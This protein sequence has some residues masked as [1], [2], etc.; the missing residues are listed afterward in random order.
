[1]KRYRFY[2]LALLMAGTLGGYAQEEAAADTVT[3][4]RPASPIKKNVKTRPVS[5]RVFAVTSGTPLGG[6][7]VSVS[8]Y[9]GYSTLTE[10]DGTYKLD[11]PE[12]A[13][14][15]TVTAPD[16]NSVRVGINQSGKLRDV[17]L[18]SSVMRSAYSADDNILNTVVAD[19][20]D[21]SPSLNIT[22]EIGDQLG[23]NVRTISR[24]GTPGIGNFM[25]MNGINSLHSNAQPLIVID[26]VIVD[27]Q[28]DRT[29]VH[30]GFY[31]DI[32]TSFNVNEIKSVKVMA[33]GTAI[34]GAK[35]AN[36]VILIE[37]K[38]NTS[39]ATK[40][41]ATVSAGITLLPKSLPMMSGSQ[42]KTYASDLLKTTGTNLSEFQFLT[43]DPNN[44][45]YNKY[46]NNTDWNDVIYREAFSQ[47]YGITVQGGD[48]VA[49]YFLALGYNG[50]Q[51]VLEDND[52]NRLNI[53]FNTDINMFKHLF[54]RFDASYSNVTR[55]LKDQGAPEAYDEGTVT[56]VNYLGLVKS[57]MLSPYAYSN[58]KI[59][60]V[61]F[62]NSDEDYLDQA[63]S[64]IGN[65]NY[66]LANPA[67]INEYGTAQN[68]N[69]FENSYLNLAVTPK[70]QFNKHL[71][72]S[73]LFSYTLTNTNDKYYVPI[74]GVPDYYV[75]SIGLTVENEIRSLYSSQNSITSDTK[76]EWGNQYGAHSIDLLGGFRYMNDRYKVDTQLGYNTGS[77]KTPFINDTQ[78]K[79]TTGSTNEW[80]SMSW[81]GQARYDYRKRYFVEG[82]LAI[83]SSSRFGK[84]AKEGF[85][86]AGVRWGVFPGIQA[87]WVL[88]NESWFDVPG[89][90]YAKF[91]MGYD[92]SGN[93]GIDF[94]ATRTYFQSILFQNQANGLVLGNLGNTEVQWETTRRFSFG[95]ELNFLKNRLNLKVNVFKSWTDNLLTYHELNFI[96]GLENNW[97]NGGSLENKG[98]N[99]TVN[100]HIIAT[101]N[102]NWELG[103]SVGHYK[104][105][106]TALPD[107]QDYVDVEVY[108]ATIRS[109]I[110]QPV[111]LFYG[112]K[113]E[114]TAAGTSVYATSEEAASDGLYILGE[115]GIDKTYFGAGDVKFADNGDKEI[116]K[117]DM[118]IIGDPN[119]DI[120][121]NIFTSLS[122]KR[123]RLD[124]NFN[125]SLGNDAY[126]YLRSQLE[127][128][129]RFMNQS[130]TMVNRWSYEG[131]KTDMPTATWEDPMG[132]ARFSDRWIEDAS[133]LRLK[134]ITL[135]YELPINNTFIHGLTFWGQAN[136]VFT[137]SKYLGADPDFS[138]SNSVLEQGIDRGLLANSRSFMLGIKINL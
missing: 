84:D 58:G 138:M 105:K 15:L 20:F 81:Y 75:S 128:G 79:T 10:E 13:T 68:K 24:G 65:V 22:S 78:N 94:D 1:M 97:V 6:A 46:N 80:T 113:T 40:I 34:Y 104:N 118:Q 111:N 17:T 114:T 57:P 74:N 56:S 31:N 2:C 12:F 137:V 41:D 130:I 18:Y 135:S 123:I 70:W 85:K 16:Y 63:L 48:E 101:R 42:F 129:S 27:Q 25:M 86:L 106:L 64:S 50:A 7:L 99:I 125:Y 52:V 19:K 82:N 133:Y 120:Y 55:N 35:G 49:S 54:I 98:Y 51:S 44:Y 91:T 71:S 21:Y 60:D 131:Q 110:G 132:N 122:Y 67:S 83:E 124:V 116:N 8:G 38:R 66:R 39:L 112:Y 121:G 29:M 47:N 4:A 107:G 69:Y 61:A 9:D 5:G 100:G 43:S 36:G 103:A 109:Q 126:N 26:G 77:D 30:D 53:R 102:W 62:D 136:N 73:S 93:D 33:N 87:G 134:S 115:N 32:L 59:S 119:P 23:A 72:L 11:V 95:T 90:D 14:A 37:T 117:A 89:I 45:Y 3:A 108:G 76:I 96:T 127:G 92:V 88:S 28:Y